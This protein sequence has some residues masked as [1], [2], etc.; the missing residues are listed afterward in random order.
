MQF[1]KQNQKPRPRQKPRLPET[2]PT[3]PRLRRLVWWSRYRGRI[4]GMSLSKKRTDAGRRAG[5]R[6]KGGYP[7]NPKDGVH[8]AVLLNAPFL[9]PYV[10]A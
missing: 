9:M 3:N 10:C 2:L 1:P 8:Q 4:I 7:L 5:P 6:K